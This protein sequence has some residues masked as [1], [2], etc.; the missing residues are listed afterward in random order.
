MAGKITDASL[1]AFHDGVRR[2]IICEAGYDAFPVIPGWW[3]SGADVIGMDEPKEADIKWPHVAWYLHGGCTCLSKLVSQSTAVKGVTAIEFGFPREISEKIIEHVTL[4]PGVGDKMH[5][6]PLAKIAD[7]GLMV[8][9]R[10]DITN[11]QLGEEWAS[12]DGQ[13]V[14]R[15]V[16]YGTEDP[17]VVSGGVKFAVAK[18]D[19]F[20]HPRTLRQLDHVEWITPGPGFV[21]FDD[22][23][24]IETDTD[25][26]A[27]LDSV[28][29]VLALEG[30]TRLE[31][32]QVRYTL[33]EA[34]DAERGD[35]IDAG[36]V[37]ETV[38]HHNGA[39]WLGAYDAETDTIQLPREAGLLPTQ[40]ER[41]QAMHAL[42]E[43]IRPP[44]PQRKPMAVAKPYVEEEP[45][46]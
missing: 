44:R 22:L 17:I 4:R 29:A 31:S 15:V 35:I 12:P 7:G 20:G 32:K 6:M 43:S 27:I 34:I 5:D 45:N 30:W 28:T 38:S 14:G 13:R 36:I 24:R 40:A 11:G 39:T 3:P 18:R 8:L 33:R 41:E 25:L 42:A 46:Q 2:H 21:P 37:F 1:G 9:G 26:P 19:Y 16:L 10:G 23:L